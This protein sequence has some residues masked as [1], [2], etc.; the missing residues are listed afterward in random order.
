MF[1]NRKIVIGAVAMSKSRMEVDSRSF[2]LKCSSN[3]IFSVRTYVLFVLIFTV[4]EA[5]LDT[6]S[7]LRPQSKQK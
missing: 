5:N 7:G 1:L 4:V 2:F 3:S 6:L